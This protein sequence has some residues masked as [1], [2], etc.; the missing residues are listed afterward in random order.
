MASRAAPAEGFVRFNTAG[1][2]VH[3]ASEMRGKLSEPTTRISLTIKQDYARR[4][5]HLQVLSASVERL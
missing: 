4:R 2:V 3:H 1:Y 5:H